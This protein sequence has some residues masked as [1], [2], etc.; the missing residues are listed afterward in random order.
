MMAPSQL[1]PPPIQLQFPW[2]QVIESQLPDAP[3]PGPPLSTLLFLLQAPKANATS[4]ATIN[5]RVLVMLAS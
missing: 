2:S 5:V 1:L 4:S 3:V